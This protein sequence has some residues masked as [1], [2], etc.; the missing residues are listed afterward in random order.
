MIRSL[1]RAF[2]AT[3]LLLASAANAAEYA[4]FSDMRLGLFVHYTHAGRP[5]AA[6]CTTQFDGA[7]VPSLDALADG[8]D[9]ANLVQTAQ[10]MQAQYLQIT[11]W[12]ANMN[13]LFPSKVLAN[14]LPGHSSR[15]DVI[16]ELLDAL[17]PTGIRLVLYL[18]PSDGMD[19]SPEDQARV[20]WNDPAPYLRWRDFID[21]VFA[22]VADR[23]GDD[24]AGYWIDGGLPPQVD[25]A[26]LRAVL[27]RRH[28]KAWMIQNSGLNPACVDY[29]ANETF[30]EPYR[31]T[32]WQMNGVVTGSWWAAGNSAKITPE[33]AYQYT[34]LQ[35]GTTGNTGGVAWS[36]GPYPG[37]KWETGIP[38]FTV[39]LGEYVARNA[40]ALFETRPSAAY[41]TA[42]G[43]PLREARYVA[44]Q[45]PD[46][47]RT[48]LHVLR[49]PDTT[50]LDLPKPA[51]GRVFTSASL[52]PGG[53]PVTLL[54]NENGVRLSLREGSQWDALD[55]V[56]ALK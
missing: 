21:E 44:T 43:T 39:K 40:S 1:Y 34:V 24:V 53:A 42:A 11:A 3:G 6:G 26:R 45:D 16:R 29:G 17:R 35:A 36:F 18:H 47:T 31:A 25:P 32:Q 2:I 23:Y 30:E 28:P 49:P 52:W 55:T 22:E 46:G 20:G 56:L 37:G 8:L 50:T 27:Q 13:A 15:R 14:R 41:P 7:P 12:H 38:E 33:L 54:Q 51:N 5:Y 4:P 48:Y 19:F 10:T 9:I